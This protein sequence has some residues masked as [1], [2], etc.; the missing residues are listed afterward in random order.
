MAVYGS[1]SPMIE[2]QGEVEGKAKA[3]TPER[4]MQMAWGYA[5]TLIVDAALYHR[6][7]DLLDGGA[8]TAR[9]LAATAQTSERG[10]RAIVE[11]LVG[12]KLL[13][14]EG[15]RYALTAEAAAFLVSS[16]PG[17]HGLFYAHA[18][19]QLLPKWMQLREVVKSGKPVAAQSQGDSATFFANFVE[20]LFPISYPA[21]RA[22]GEYLK[23]AQ[24]SRPLS[25]LDVGAGSGVWGI[26][27]AE[28]SQHVTVRAVDWPQVLEVTRRVAEGHGVADRFSYAS[29]D[30][31]QA[32]FGAG[33]DIAVL[34]HILHS[35]GPE[36]IR[37]LLRKINAAMAP[38]GAIAVME[39]VVNDDRNGPPPA[40]M[41]A[42]N[43]LVNTEHGSTYTF[44]EISDWLREAGFVNAR[45][46]AV[47]AVS[48]LILANKPEA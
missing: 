9:E 41:F 23:V 1:W 3:P 28:Q 39:F 2:A 21:A 12:F 8:K 45:T 18:V 10:A 32:N 48:P 47:P 13:D 26:A 6:F 29:G 25:V 5:V 20:S 11:A 14:R 36:Q 17:F 19:D 15:D 31:W 43:M 40:L 35:E 38:G 27:L 7:F 4:L 46:L 37:K 22:L 34:G 42:V 24:S 33:H 30:L 44:A 16:R